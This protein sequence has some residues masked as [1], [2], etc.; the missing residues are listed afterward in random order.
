VTDSVLWSEF[1]NV[2]GAVDFADVHAIDVIFNGDLGKA[3][4]D[5]ALTPPTGF[6]VPE[7]GSLALTG[8]ALLG[9]GAVR[10]GRKS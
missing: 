4:I 5:L 10:R 3:S 6:N 8:L 1:V 2:A 7:P 9:L